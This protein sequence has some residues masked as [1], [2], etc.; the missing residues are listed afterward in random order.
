MRRRS[1]NGFT[2]IELMIT[3]A[4]V[5]I[6]ASIAIPAYRGS[7]NRSMRA[8]AKAVLLENAQFLE[9]NFTESNKYNKDA[10]NEDVVLPYTQ[11]PHEGTAQYTISL[12]ATASTFTL[13]AAPIIGGSMEKDICGSFTLNQFGLKGISGDSQYRDDCWNK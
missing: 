10:S 7:V 13:T 8:D 2:L 5:G 3:V 6:L 4:I 1:K 11:A 9:R 12:S